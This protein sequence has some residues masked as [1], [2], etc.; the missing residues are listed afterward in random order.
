MVEEDLTIFTRQNGSTL[1]LADPE[2]FLRIDC[3]FGMSGIVA[4]AHFDGF[5]NMCAVVSG[6][7]RI[8]LT[9]PRFC[10]NAYM[11][12]F[13]H[14][15]GRHSMNDWARPDLEK[16]PRFAGMHAH[17]VLLSAGEILFIPS[18]WLHYVVNLDTKIPC[19][20]FSDQS[21]SGL[22]HIE[23]CGFGGLY[24]GPKAL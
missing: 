23:A 24:R 3:R 18:W 16:Y 19:N 15:S 4:E 7:R 22:E 6:T 8:V 21:A 13:D 17:E 2:K 1:F 14:P 5:R 20:S 12:P 10:E 11:F 9:H